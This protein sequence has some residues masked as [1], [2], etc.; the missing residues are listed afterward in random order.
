[1]CPLP[2][3]GEELNSKSRKSSSSQYVL[4]DGAFVCWSTGRQKNKRWEW[5][6]L[7]RKDIC[8]STI[9]FNVLEIETLM[10]MKYQLYSIL[11][12]LAAVIAFAMKSIQSSIFYLEKAKSLQNFIV[13]C[14]LVRGGP[15]TADSLFLSGCR[16][17][18]IEM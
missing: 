14:W 15:E 9:A 7:C 18:S 8:K 3:C 6:R 17:R 4:I 12:D 2:C 13:L 10:L 11:I 16:G 1:M 5:E